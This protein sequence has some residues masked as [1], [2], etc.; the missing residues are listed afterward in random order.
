MIFP[1]MAVFF[2]LQSFYILT[3]FKKCAENKEEHEQRLLM[4]DLIP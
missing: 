1:V 2:F 4:I 3:E